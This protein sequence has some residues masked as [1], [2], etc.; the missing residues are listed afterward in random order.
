MPASAENREG[1]RLAVF[2][3]RDNVHRGRRILPRIPL[4]SFVNNPLTNPSRRRHRSC[5]GE[6]SDGTD[7]EQLLEQVEI[8]NVQRVVQRGIERT[9]FHES[10]ERNRRG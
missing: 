3:S 1:P 9:V 7:G 5:V 8:H 10:K 6:I 4:D 2:S